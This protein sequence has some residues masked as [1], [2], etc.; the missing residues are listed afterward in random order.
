[1]TLMT[2]RHAITMRPHLHCKVRLILVVLIPSKVYLLGSTYNYL[3][4][5]L[6]FVASIAVPF[7]NSLC[8]NNNSK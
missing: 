5:F 6:I 3:R 1:M 7:E 4:N 2:P 8:T